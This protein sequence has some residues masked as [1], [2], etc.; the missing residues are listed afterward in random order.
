MAL[1]EDDS[2]YLIIYCGVM[3]IVT[4]LLCYCGAFLYSTVVV[5]LLTIMICRFIDMTKRWQSVLF[6]AALILLLV[7]NLMQVLR[8]RVALADML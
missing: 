4:L 6:G 5:P 8:F 2:F 1:L 7:N 3:V